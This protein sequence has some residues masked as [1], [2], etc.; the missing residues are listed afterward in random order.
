[1]AGVALLFGVDLSGDTKE[2][3]GGAMVLLA[4]LCY[5]IG[6]MLIKHKARGVP[7]VAVAG[8]TMAISALVTLPLFLASLPSAVPHAKVIGSLL[9]LGAGGT[10]IAFLF[11]Y[12]L[13]AELGPARASVVAYI[14]PGFSVFYGAVLLGEQLTVAG[15]IGLLLIVAGSWL[16]AQGGLPRRLS[17]SGPSHSTAPEPVR[18]R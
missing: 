15:I 14:A 5:A 18:A 10:G 9:V 11:F 12:T 3:V 13:I 17:R 6:A 8:S 2:L 16:G 4:G 1:M 7:P